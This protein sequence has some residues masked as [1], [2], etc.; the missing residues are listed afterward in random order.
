MVPDAVVVKRNIKIL[1]GY[2]GRMS[3]IMLILVISTYQ[4]LK[5]FV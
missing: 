1:N 3:H 2:K 4:N 5:Y